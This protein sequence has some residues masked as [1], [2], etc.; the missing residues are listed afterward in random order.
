M[1]SKGK[2][3]QDAVKRFDRTRTLHPGEA[4]ELVPQPGPRQI[5]TRP[6]R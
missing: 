1:S 2:K 3:Y 6:S 4:M 5:L